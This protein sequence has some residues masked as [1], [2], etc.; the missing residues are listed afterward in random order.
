MTS[1]GRQSRPF[2]GLIV[3]SAQVVLEVLSLAAASPAV[4]LFD[5]V[6]VADAAVCHL[7]CL[8]VVG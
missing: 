6:V 5:H 2:V 7:R 1:M 8:V 4:A 3:C